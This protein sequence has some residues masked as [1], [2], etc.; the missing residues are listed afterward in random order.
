[1]VSALYEEITSL[2]ERDSLIGIGNTFF[3]YFF[4]KQV[5]NTDMRIR[6]TNWRSTELEFSSALLRG[7]LEVTSDE[8]ELV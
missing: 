7:Y 1:M 6:M 4:G 2:I 8:N 3:I 5:H